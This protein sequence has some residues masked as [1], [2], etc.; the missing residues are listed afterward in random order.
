MSTPTQ[1][2]LSPAQV[3]QR[4]NVSRRTVMRAVESLQ[5]KAI[6]DNR[7]HWKIVAQNAEEWA[8]AQC[9]PSEQIPPEM[10][11]TA[12]PE[13]NHELAAIRAENGQLKER[14][15][16][17]EADRDHWREMAIKLADRPRF[18]WPWKR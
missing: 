12:H 6:R 13:I 7:N 8:D 11:S 3:A 9:A 17:T 15:S 14:L 4:Y 5:L 18:R 2:F 16:A 10:P 1:D